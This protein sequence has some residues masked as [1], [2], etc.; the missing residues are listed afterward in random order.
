MVLS[1]TCIST[2]DINIPI[3]KARA[4]VIST[5]DVLRLFASYANETSYTVWET[6]VNNLS[7]LDR[8]LS[9]TDCY[10]NF[11]TYAIKLFTPAMARLGWDP[12]DKDSKG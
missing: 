12:R 1:C 11:K 4:G 9:Y 10:E 8:L 7:V 2:S 3:Q 5:T 6:L